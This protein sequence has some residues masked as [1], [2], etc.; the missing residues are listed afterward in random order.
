MEEKGSRG[1][2]EENRRARRER[3]EASDGEM[4]RGGVETGELCRKHA[5]DLLSN[6]TVLL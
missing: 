2:R 3:T 6:R 1:E 4:L 5:K